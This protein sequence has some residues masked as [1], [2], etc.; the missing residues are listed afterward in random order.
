MNAPYWTDGKGNTMPTRTAARGRLGA[1]RCHFAADGRFIGFARLCRRD[2]RTTREWRAAATDLTAIGYYPT[3][4][5][6]GQALRRRK[7]TA[8]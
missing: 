2:G 4:A 6:A 1:L 8:R 7:G 5:K 3:L